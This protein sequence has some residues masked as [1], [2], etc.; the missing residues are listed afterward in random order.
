MTAGRNRL[1]PATLAA[2]ALGTT[3]AETGAVVPPMHSSTTFARG[4]DYRLVGGHLYSRDSAP[5]VRRA[6][7]IVAALDGGPDARLF[8]SGMA[9]FAA[10]LE[11]LPEGAHVLAPKSMYY[12]AQDWLIRLAGRGRIGLD[13][14]D[15]TRPEALSA[16]LRP[17][18]TAMVW[19]E[20]PANPTWDVVDIAAAAAAAHEAGAMLAVDSTCAPPPTTRPLEL[21]ADIVFHS[22]TKYLNGHSD[23]TAGALVP[24]RED[25]LWA[26]IHKVRTA[27]GGVLGGFEAWLLIRGMRTLH[28]RFA[29]QSETALAL[30]RHL[31]GH[32][33]VLEVLYPGLAGHPGHA[34]A[35]RQMTGGFGGMMSILVDGDSETARRVAAATRVF[36][37]ATSLGGVESLIEHRRS[38][39]SPQS[40]VADTLIRISVGLE[41]P[42]DLIDDL[43]QALSAA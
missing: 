12:A 38:V 10:L 39:E 32:P 30:A 43:E 18:R 6:E 13:L 14:F 20:T 11:A 21:G 17:G 15:Q 2:Q 4:A 22:A 1:D 33:R 26:Q 24:A 28:V 27:T 16:A 42:G 8:A 31:E 35:R 25:E 3:D 34:V 23:L 36:V 37:P 29:R 40:P 41:A 5:T 7:E 9:A 19:I